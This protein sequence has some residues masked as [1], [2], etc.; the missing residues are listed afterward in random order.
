MDRPG[1][2]IDPGFHVQFFFIFQ[3]KIKLFFFY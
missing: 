3:Q 1:H 2:N